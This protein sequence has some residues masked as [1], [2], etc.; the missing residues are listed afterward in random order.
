MGK[1]SYD[2]DKDILSK[3]LEDSVSCRGTLGEPI[4]SNTERL[5]LV[6]LYLENCSEKQ[7][8]HKVTSC[9]DSGFTSS[10]L[11]TILYRFYFMY[12]YYKDYGNFCFS[13][14]TSMVLLRS[15]YSPLDLSGRVYQGTEGKKR[16]GRGISDRILCEINREL[17][18]A[19]L[20]IIKYGI[21]SQELKDRYLTGYHK[22][23]P[24]GCI[25]RYM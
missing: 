4:L 16:I 25:N 6:L 9:I 21:S 12:K 11:D 13:S 19:D 5:A 1:K 3:Y 7:V 14:K 10:R 22:L 15:G 23:A 24:D 18:K 17:Y 2:F 20:P 8:I